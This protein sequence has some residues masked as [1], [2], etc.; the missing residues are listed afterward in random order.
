MLALAG[1][2]MAQQG[3]PTTP[4]SPAVEG[5]RPD[6]NADD[7]IKD[8]GG[9]TQV[10][11]PFEVVDASGKVILSVGTDDDDAGVSIHVAEGAGALSVHSGTALTV[12]ELGTD[13]NGNGILRT[14]NAQGALR[15]GISGE[16]VASVFDES[17][18]TRLATLGANAHGAGSLSLLNKN[19]QLGVEA[20]AGTES[21][22]GVIR[23][24][25]ANGQTAAGVGVDSQGR[26]LI[27]V[28]DTGGTAQLSISQA[29]APALMILDKSNTQLAAVDSVNG[30]GRVA[31]L[32]QGRASAELKAAEAGGGS[33]VVHSSGGEPI[34]AVG[35]GANGRGGVT[36]FKNG[37]DT[38]VL[39]TNDSGA[40]ALSLQN[41][42]GQ[43]G[44]V[45]MG[46]EGS[47]GGSV[48]V[49][50]DAGEAVAG[51]GASE[52]GK[53]RISVVEND[54]Q[55][56]VLKADANG[57][58]S[59]TL[60]TTEGKKGVEATGQGGGESSGGSVMVFNQAEEEAVTLRVE[61]QGGGIV[62]AYSD[63][64]VAAELS[65]DS[66]NLFDGGEP[67][68]ALESDPGQLV[69][70]DQGGEAVTVGLND[71]QVGGV[72]IY[73]QSTPLV[74]LAEGE[75]GGVILVK[76]AQNR[77]AVQ[78]GAGTGGNG[79]FKS[80]A[81]GNVVSEMGSYADG[82]GVFM[83][84]SPGTEVPA[85]VM[86]RSPEYAGGLVQL[87]NTTQVVVSLTAGSLG[88]GHLELNNQSGVPM[89]QAGVT[90]DGRGM[91]A[92]QPSRC[93]PSGMG[94]V[95]PDCIVGAQQK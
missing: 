62:G 83:V 88:Q 19:G 66:L 41:A 7:L 84:R 77:D 55:V 26:G 47:F 59:V 13:E 93:A 17:G 92:T 34:V 67:I 52:D 1:W 80:F 69:V 38:A 9:I 16:G 30:K 70:F 6:L 85:A 91:V 71:Q 12:A 76:N 51:V 44:L 78:L 42:Q 27:A 22:G 29:G 79:V 33:L 14:N 5:L 24:M 73:E 18:E 61:D 75:H 81:A 37:I 89:V 68:L 3:S 86:T 36:I 15:A 48:V 72:V 40:G 94:L 56:A 63:E 35:A 74:W 8:V 2:A 64:D 32:E 87:T 28:V 46:A 53:G 25:N 39:T 90:T 50:N 23:T 82:R 10:N 95:I 43:D 21:D 31:I 4:E 58:G 49:H 45:A 11:A 57:S 54:V 20:A 60:M 65:G